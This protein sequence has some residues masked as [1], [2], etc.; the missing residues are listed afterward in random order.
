MNQKPQIV[1]FFYEFLHPASDA[2]VVIPNGINTPFATS[3][4]KFFINGKSTYDNGP[5]SLSKNPLDCIILD[6]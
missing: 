5:R 3:D 1:R 2:A 4:S 6:S